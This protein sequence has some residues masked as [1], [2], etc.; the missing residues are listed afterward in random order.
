MKKK[1]IHQ[2]VDCIACELPTQERLNYFT[3]QFLT[4]R[5]FQDE[6]S[7]L[8]GKHRQ[9]NRY[10]HGY[11]TVCGLKV[12]QH[13]NP[14]CRDRFIIIQ[15]GF[16]LDC[17]GREILVREPVYVDLDKALAPQN[18]GTPNGKHLLISLCYTECKS[19]F[20]PVL[21]AECGC[22]ET[23]MEANRIYERFAVDVQLVDTV[24]KSPITEPTKI[25]LQWN[26]TINLAQSL[27]LAVDSV[28]KR[29]YVLTAANP[30]QIMVYNTDNGVQL[31]TILLGETG[32]RGVDLAIDISGQFLYIIRHTEGTPPTYDL[33][34]MDLQ[35]ANT[36]V[37]TL[38][39]TTGELTNPPQVMVSTAADHR[40]YT[41]DPNANP[42]TITIWKTTINTE[43]VDPTLPLSDP[44]SPKFAEVNSTN[45]VNAFA[46]SPDGS[47]LFLA[48][49]TSNQIRAFKVDTLNQPSASQV[50]VTVSLA[51]N[52]Q[53]L[54]VSG[55]SSQLYVVTA[56][57]AGTMKLRAFEIEDNSPPTITEINAPGVSLGSGNAI[58]L[59]AAP[60]EKW[61]YLLS[62]DDSNNG[63][64]RPISTV[65]L[66]TDPNRAVFDAIAVFSNPQDLLLDN[67]LTRIYAAGNTETGGV[68][69]L[70]IQSELCRELLW[71]TLNDCSSCSDDC[72]P[73]AVVRDYKT[74]LEITDA[75]IDN[76]IR[77]LIPSTETLQKL[78]LCALESHNSMGEGSGDGV[79]S[80]DAETVD[81]DVPAEA[82][83]NPTT[84]NIHFK[85]PKGRD[86]NDGKD[87]KDGI[88]LELNLPYIEAVS[89]RHN[90]PNNSLITIEEIPG[91]FNQGIVIG[92][93]A[94]VIVSDSANPDRQIIDSHVFQVLAE[95]LER[96][97]F[98]LICRCQ[99][100]GSVVPVKFTATNNL[101]QS[102]TFV[103]GTTAMGIAFV[104][105]RFALSVLRS[106]QPK[107]LWVRLL[108]D[109]VIDVN[110]KK[111]VDAKFIQALLP[112]GLQRPSTNRIGTQGGVFESW[113]G[114]NIG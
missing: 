29:L 52:P 67:S 20:V 37:N 40:I 33:Q 74:G 28:G 18:N 100:T 66:K 83:F 50:S 84:G 70:E 109:F 68:S 101:I 10:L 21:Y 77:P 12:E 19:E 9:H 113:F 99:L 81:P 93:N 44:N 5:D 1:Q 39:L 97:Q 30:G 87:G 61:I 91:T 69:I 3:G 104:F 58:D 73:L 78:I 34:I 6:Q 94:P 96:E 59:V 32:V 26:G 64:V 75:L 46:V 89:W 2:S 63:E 114:F 110:Q 23:G 7:Y 85:I 82:E 51:E 24:P 38:P 88:G 35:N 98:N 42:Q 65:L 72:L 41:L 8:L 15:P 14:A 17:C 71:E 60:S 43:S 103:Q 111:A 56:P 13:P 48:E 4:E 27:R 45:E 79:R 57:S 16:A 62:S 22:D 54:A 25:N 112:T 86:G 106:L 49:G 107:E 55:D 31:P 105:D 80:A 47:W 36:V 95:T 90:T 53:V 108:G 102:A 92:F 11:G 76:R